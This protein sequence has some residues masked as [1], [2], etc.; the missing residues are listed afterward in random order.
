[1]TTT[2]TKA[3]SS[4]HGEY[5]SLIAH[6]HALAR[7]KGWWDWPRSPNEVI[8]CFASEV[9]E[10][11]EEYRVGKMERYYDGTKPCGFW[12]EI[13]DLL[14]RIADY[15]GHINKPINRRPLGKTDREMCN[16]TAG[17]IA[18]LHSVVGEMYAANVRFFR[19]RSVR[20]FAA[21]FYAASREGI[22]L[23]EEIA[24]KHSHNQKRSFRHGGKQA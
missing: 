2:A 4:Q 5:K 24:I 11:W 19:D 16:T 3:T 1:M 6:S 15:H 10:A 18:F 8:N 14:I 17:F 7:E 9:S 12:I 23:W 20:I 22:D 21:C 13:A